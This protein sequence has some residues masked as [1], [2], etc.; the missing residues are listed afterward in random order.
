MLLVEDGEVSVEEGQ[1]VV[2]NRAGSKSTSVS[3]P[4]VK[5]REGTIDFDDLVPTAIVTISADD[6]ERSHARRA[7]YFADRTSVYSRRGGPQTTL[8]SDR[9]H[10][11][12]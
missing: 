4:A 12:G 9:V 7:G 8:E 5:C 1:V 11:A 2:T 3:G 6:M 10:S